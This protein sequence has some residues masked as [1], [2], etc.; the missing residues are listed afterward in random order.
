MKTWDLEEKIEDAFT[1]YLKKEIPDTMKFYPAWTDENIQ[2]PCAVAKAGPSTPIS[3][4]APWTDYRNSQ[5][6]IAVMSEAAPEKNGT[7]ATLRTARERNADARRLVMN[8]LAIDSLAAALNAM[9]VEGVNFSF[10][11]ATTLDRGL[12]ERVLVSIITVEVKTTPST[13]TA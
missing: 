6:E 4:T 13:V 9:N 1:A 10:A 3:E 8:A 7:G 2:F 5:V 11:Q 12:E